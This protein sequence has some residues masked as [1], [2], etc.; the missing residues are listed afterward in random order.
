MSQLCQTAFHN[1]E[2]RSVWGWEFRSKCDLSRLIS[3]N[4][5]QKPLETFHR[6]VYLLDRL[7]HSLFQQ[8]NWVLCVNWWF[9]LPNSPS[10]Q[11]FFSCYFECHVDT[12]ADPSEH[13]TCLNLLLPLH[14]DYRT[15]RSKVLLLSCSQCWYRPPR[16]VQIN[17][18]KH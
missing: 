11:N 13:N 16:T 2:W 5:D 12:N 8:V 1:C 6:Y 7:R 18:N 15:L 9:R 10:K 3:L 17:S 14:F 4:F